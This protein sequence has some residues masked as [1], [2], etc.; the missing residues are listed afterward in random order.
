MILLGGL[1]LNMLHIQRTLLFQVVPQD[2]SKI[3]EL[4]TLFS[5]LSATHVQIFDLLAS[6]GSGVDE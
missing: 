2:L 1:S 3:D 5:Q 6:P 4:S